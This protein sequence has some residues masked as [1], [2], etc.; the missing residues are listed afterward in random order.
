MVAFRT[1]LGF[2]AVV[3]IPQSPC[4]VKRNFLF[5]VFIFTFRG[6]KLYTSS[7]SGCFLK[8][9]P[10]WFAAVDLLQSLCFY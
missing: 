5:A 4:F 8:T 10:A 6:L 3:V 2:C 7:K 1:Q 9:V